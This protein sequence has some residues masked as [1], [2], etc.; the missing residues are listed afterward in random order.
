MTIISLF[1]LFFSKLK[2]IKL[3]IQKANNG[4]V[5][6]LRG[7]AYKESIH[8]NKD[9]TLCGD[10]NGNTVLEGIFLIPKGVR[11]TFQ[12]LSI[13]PTAQLYVEGEGIFEQCSITSGIDVLITVNN[14]YIKCSNCNFSKAKEI[15][16][17]L[18]N[19]GVGIFEHCSFQYNES[20]QL[21]SKKSKLYLEQ[22]EFLY[23]KHAICL[24]DRSFMQ[25]N[26]CYISEH[27][28]NQ[29]VVKDSTLIDH[30]SRI[31]KGQ[32]HGLYCENQSDVSLNS[33]LMN[34]HQ[35]AQLFVENSQLK[36]KQCMI[37]FG[38]QTGIKLLSTEAYISNC[39][40]SNHHVANVY[41]TKKSKMHMEHCQ[42][43]LGKGYGVYISKESI[44]NFY[45]TFF[46]NHQH[47]QLMIT[48]KSFASLKDCSIIQGQHVGLFIEK[49]S[50][51]MLAQCK[52]LQN[53]NS[54]I[55]ADHS[56]LSVYQCYIAQNNGNGI[57][58]IAHSKVEVDSSEFSNN[59]MPHI[60]CRQKVKI[61]ILDSDFHKGKSIFVLERC[62]LYA[63]KSKFHNSLNVQIELND[64]CTGKFEQ[65]QI[66]N[67]K[68]YGVKVLKNSNFFLYHSQISRHELAQIVVNDS[69]VILND[70][71]VFKGKRNGLFI[72]NHS[73]VFIQDSYISKH[74]QPQIWIDD[75]SILELV[76]VQLTD[77]AH[78]DL[79]VQNQSK[80]YVT[81]SIIR[82]E[83][84]RYNVQALNNSK[85]D[86]VKTI[87]EN[88]Y[89]DVYYSENNSSIN[90]SD[91]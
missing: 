29:M 14:G 15:G 73:E 84:Y 41:V 79:H 32:N 63:M 23:G 4:D 88:K 56:R 22:C 33:T 21:L 39:E 67:G 26:H 74:L 30:K 38:N 89:G 46:K 5:I 8:F 2:T 64:E 85:I 44:A 66:Y 83:N 16:V 78:S 72:Q 68:S 52:L 3:S 37:L 13:S 18:L 42:V 53:G 60:A 28:D 87:V 86:L 45:G 19:N 9:V 7:K 90:N 75:E 25:S 6:Q 31:E 65:C 12:D 61:H 55:N 82:N 11:V 70:S 81:S 76:S 77:G 58:A 91:Y 49:K 59:L 69:S 27:W 54:A 20:I 47:P 24:T 71:E 1:S 51:C 57:L 40:I 80:V 48:E 10:P 36:A 50:E 17:A 34:T 62:E 43:H 35:E